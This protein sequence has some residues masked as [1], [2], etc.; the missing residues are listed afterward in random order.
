VVEVSSARAGDWRVEVIGS[1]IPE[2]PQDFAVVILG[3]VG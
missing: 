1:N 3:R 2:G